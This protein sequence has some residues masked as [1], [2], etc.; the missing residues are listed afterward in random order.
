M[1]VEKLIHAEGND[2]VL[3]YVLSD[4][5]I[6]FMFVVAEAENLGL[7][8]GDRSRYTDLFESGLLVFDEYSSGKYG[9]AYLSEVGIDVIE[10]LD[11]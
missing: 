3:R 6:E 8:V 5:E 4:A 11:R 1:D 7:A 10:A 2:V 9:G